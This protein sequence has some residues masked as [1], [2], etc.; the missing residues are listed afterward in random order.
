MKKKISNEELI[1]MYKKMSLIRE[2]EERINVLYQNDLVYGAGHL[3]VGE[4]ACSV[5]VCSVLE[6]DDYVVSNHR[7]HGHC[8]AKGADI[9]K[10]IAELMGKRTGYCRGKG[11]S[12]HIVDFG[13][14]FIG[15][16]GIV[17]AGI[18]IAA[19][20]AGLNSKV[21]KLNRV[22]VSF[23]GDGAANTGSFHE[24]INLAA[25][26]S[27]PVVYIIENN[28]YAVT[29]SISTACN[30]EDL[31]KRAIAY[32]IPGKKVGGNNIFEVYDAAKEAVNKARKGDG[33]SLIECRTYRWYGHYIGDPGKY[34]PKGELEKWKN[35]DPIDFL[36]KYLLKN[37]ILSKKD[38]EKIGS[39]VVEKIDKA[40]EFGKNSPEPQLSSITEDVY[41][42]KD[43]IDIN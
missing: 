19:G 25:C 29:T 28:L 24:G 41:F 21:N 6:P 33:P 12:M 9:N 26:L 13:I 35:R 22:A 17:G 42:T 15:A 37:N 10:M 8:I 5:G 11:G 18:A 23:C 16:Q 1:G 32:G 30:L 27:L 14:N 34:R 31:Y 43:Q 40:V 3:S 36:R 2:F 7:G 20:G 38:I 39:E 4:E